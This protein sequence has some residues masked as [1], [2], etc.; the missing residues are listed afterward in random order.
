[1][2]D[3]RQVYRAYA[4]Y[5][6]DMQA[7][8]TANPSL[9]SYKLAPNK[10]IEGRDVH[11]VEITNNVTAKDGKPVFY[12]QGAIH[13]NESAAAEDSMEFAIDIV[14][15]SKAN[16]KVSALLDHVRVVILPLVNPDGYAHLP[17]P[18]RAELQPRDAAHAA[19]DLPHVDVPRRRHEPQLSDGLGLEH[20]RVARPARFRPGL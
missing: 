8:E 3:N 20:R 18:R 19:A 1:M 13:G 9:V 5:N 11:Y 12:V 14:N 2:P 10:T 6:N 7:L 17:S 4:D 15:Q 16:P